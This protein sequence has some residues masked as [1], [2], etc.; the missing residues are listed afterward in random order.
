MYNRYT[1]L[2]LKT[3]MKAQQVFS[4]VCSHKNNQIYWCQRTKKKE[5]IYTC[6]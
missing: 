2:K 4:Y 3:L 6:M 5:K 1:T